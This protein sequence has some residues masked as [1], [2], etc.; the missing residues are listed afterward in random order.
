[1]PESLVDIVLWQAEGL[2]RLVVLLYETLTVLIC[3]FKPVVNGVDNIYPLK[4][5]GRFFMVFP[6]RVPQGLI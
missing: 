5:L 4:K 1:M 6:E 2:R 3:F